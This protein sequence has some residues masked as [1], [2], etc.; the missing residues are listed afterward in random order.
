MRSLL[1]LA[2]DTTTTTAKAPYLVNLYTISLELHLAHRY[3]V[4]NTKTQ[5]E[6][7][8]GLGVRKKGGARFLRP[9]TGDASSR[10]RQLDGAVGLGSKQLL[11]RQRFANQP[12]LAHVLEK[13]L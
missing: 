8:L 2:G 9:C 11:D 10:L 6:K 4:G 3:S 7:S 1:V 13:G 5:A 12:L